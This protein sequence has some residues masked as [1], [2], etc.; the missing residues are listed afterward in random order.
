MAKTMAQLD[1]NTVSNMIWCD[2][3]TAET[4]TLKDTGD[5]PVGIGDTLEDG[6]WFRDGVEILTPLEEAQKRIAELEAQNADQSAALETI[7]NGSTE[8]SA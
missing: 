1:G 8:G 5:R 7:Y 6:K 2:S 3:D 4:E